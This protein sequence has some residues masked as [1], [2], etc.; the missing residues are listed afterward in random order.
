MYVQWAGYNG[1]TD[2]YLCAVYQDAEDTWGAVMKP[3][4]IWNL[5]Q[6]E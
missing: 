1:Y 5:L 3:C 4:M 6:M 2:Q